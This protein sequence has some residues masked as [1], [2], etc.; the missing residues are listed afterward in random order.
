MRRPTLKKHNIRFRERLGA[1]KVIAVLQADETSYFPDVA[2]VLHDSGI[3][4]LETALGTPGALDAVTAMRAELG[5]DTMFGAGGVRTLSDVDACAQ[6]RVDF[7]STPTLTPAVL[8]HA[9]HYGL[10]VVC[11][12]LTPTEIDAAWRAGAAAVNIFPIGP[13]GGVDYLHAVRSPLPEIPLV[14]AGGVSL[15][16]IDSYLGAGAFAVSVGA[17]LL[18]DAVYGGRLDELGTRATNL[19]AL[20]GKFL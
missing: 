2:Q 13:A 20:A 17:P 16:D 14:P 1:T 6:A 7:L 12:A 9:Q 8:G 10:P 5:H 15:H 4:V 11:G 3:T 19:A 18:G